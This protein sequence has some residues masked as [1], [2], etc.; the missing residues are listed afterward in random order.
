MAGSLSLGVA[1]GGDGGDKVDEAEGRAAAAEAVAAAC[2]IEATGAKDEAERLRLEVRELSRWREAVFDLRG[3][4]DLAE[5]G[6]GGGGGEGDA[7]G[8]CWDGQVVEIS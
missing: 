5:C 2:A 8:W 4:V 3:A 1:G 6:G 7:G